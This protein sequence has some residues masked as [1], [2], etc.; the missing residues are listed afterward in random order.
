MERDYS[1]ALGAGGGYDG[2]LGRQ[3]GRSMSLEPTIVAVILA[4]IN[5]HLTV[6]F[7]LN[8]TIADP[9]RQDW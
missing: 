3:R 1:N 4:I 5:K 7:S 8:V 9:I 2:P 6:P